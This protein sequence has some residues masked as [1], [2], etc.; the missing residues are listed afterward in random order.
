MAAIYG[1][2]D[3]YTRPGV[4]LLGWRSPRRTEG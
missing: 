3:R 1:G 2:D 4:S